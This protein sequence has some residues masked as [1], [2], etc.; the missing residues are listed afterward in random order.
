[1]EVELNFPVPT[2]PIMLLPSMVEVNIPKLS[3]LKTEEMLASPTLK[4]CLGPLELHR[5][6]V[7]P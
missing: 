7:L 3:P 2:V 6:T 1:M 5:L 4:W